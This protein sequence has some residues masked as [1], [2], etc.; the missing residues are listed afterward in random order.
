MKEL[1][2]DI[3]EPLLTFARHACIYHSGNFTHNS[4]QANIVGAFQFTKGVPE[5]IMS[6]NNFRFI[7]VSA[8]RCAFESKSSLR[9]SPK[10]LGFNFPLDENILPKEFFNPLFFT[11]LRVNDSI[12]LVKLLGF[13]LKSLS[14]NSYEA[15]KLQGTLYPFDLSDPSLSVESDGWEP[16]V[17][18]SK[19]PRCS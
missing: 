6:S 17:S 16:G 4:N 7:L 10:S 3:I 1:L 12:L 8:S 2:T 5:A 13:E 9:L 14:S 11:P 19:S 15:L 18:A